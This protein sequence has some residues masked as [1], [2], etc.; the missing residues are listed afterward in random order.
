[1][2][3]TLY[4][5]LGSPFVYMALERLP[6]FDFGE[7]ELRPVSLGAIFMETGQSAAR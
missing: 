1:M 3:A 7:V 2:A 4:F 6:R 5:D